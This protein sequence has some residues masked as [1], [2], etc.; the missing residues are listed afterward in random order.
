MESFTPLWRVPLLSSLILFLSSWH[1]TFLSCFR[2]ILLVCAH[3][4]EAFHATIADTHF[5]FVFVLGK[6]T[7][8]RYIHLVYLRVLEADVQPDAHMGT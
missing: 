4:A 1:S 3:A 5:Q 7:S 6:H 2:N 8:Y